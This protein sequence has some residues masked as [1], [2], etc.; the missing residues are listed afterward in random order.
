MVARRPRFS[1]RWIVVANLARLVRLVIAARSF[2]RRSVKRA[3]A[4]LSASS[5]GLG[6]E[7]SSHREA[8][9]GEP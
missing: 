9:S 1:G 2:L 8:R 7:G 5:E 6:E 3:V 4:A